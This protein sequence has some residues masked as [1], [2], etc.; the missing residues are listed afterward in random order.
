MGSGFLIFFSRQN[1]RRCGFG[2]DN[3]GDLLWT[4]APSGV[5]ELGIDTVVTF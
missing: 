4:G 2:G 5:G 1:C 3:N